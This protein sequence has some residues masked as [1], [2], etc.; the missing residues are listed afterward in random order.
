VQ[1]AEP[2]ARKRH[3]SA[4]VIGLGLAVVVATVVP[5][6][7][8]ASGLL[9]G[10]VVDAR[11]TVALH[12]HWYRWLHGLEGLTS[13]L[14]YYPAPDTLGLSDAFFVQ[15]LLH[16]GLRTAGMSTIDAW[17]TTGVVM[18]LAGNVALALLSLRIL[19]RLAVR[20][21]F[22][23]AAGTSY[24]F[25]AQFVHPQ[26]AGY[27]LVPWLALLLV[28][29]WAGP[30]PR[31][32]WA[33]CLV[34]PLWVLLALSAWY[35]AAFTLLIGALAVLLAPILFPVGGLVAHARTRLL[36]IPRWLAA[37]CGVTTLGL[38]ALWAAVYL[39]VAGETTRDWYA[40]GA[41][42]APQL[43]D[44]VNVTWP[45][46]GIW[47]PLMRVTALTEAGTSVEQRLGLTPVLVVAF[48]VASVAALA[49]LS[50]GPARFA[51][52]Q[53]WCVLIVV[54]AIGLVV[55]DGRSQSLWRLVWVWVPGGSSVR[56]PMRIM[57]ILTPL[58][59]AVVLRA[60]EHL[61]LRSTGRGRIAA[62]VLVSVTCVALVVEQQ[63]PAPASWTAR[64]FIPGEYADATKALVDSGCEAFFLVPPEGDFGNRL[65]ARPEGAVAN[66]NID[67]VSIAVQTGI[68]TLNG[69]AA[70]LPLGY[71]A[72]GGYVAD[73]GAV[74]SWARAMKPDTT[75]CVVDAHGAVV[76]A[77]AP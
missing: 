4:T 1:E 71:P 48:L 54:T 53:L 31:T 45:D 58:V 42:F 64:D 28:M 21:V 43:S 77:P 63:R 3:R 47:S 35:A 20:I 69:H 74:L 23:V 50:R 55:A 22:V 8:L 49:S 65:A 14:Y 17:S 72:E 25:V 10:G 15:G 11:W 34:P 16:S 12:E 67:A 44:F 7:G 56:A 59:L 2:A 39:P 5:F 30:P 52:L 9:I 27:A 32:A 38:A 26:T 29:G 40:D 6:R 73:V 37:A 19:Q 13:T 36:T 33:W 41:P 70:R 18:V 46:G 62:L 76:R 61:M 68:P 60:L 51:R 24:A 57:I 75:L 66:S